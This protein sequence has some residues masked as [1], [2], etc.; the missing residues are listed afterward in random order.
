MKPPLTF[1]F[2]L[3]ISISFGQNPEGKIDPILLEKTAGCAEAE[4]IVV[5][6][7]QADIAPAKGLKK[8]E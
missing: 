5:M 7:E 4:F 2:A 8:K 1:L 6:S 3:L